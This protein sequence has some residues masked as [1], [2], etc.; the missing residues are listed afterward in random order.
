MRKTNQYLNTSEVRH[1]VATTSAATSGTRIVT[2]TT[3]G[4]RKGNRSWCA[5]TNI[6]TIENVFY[7]LFEAS[8][9]P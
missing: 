7:I 2:L 6:N 5:V 1:F 3:S 9:D 8:T 4:K